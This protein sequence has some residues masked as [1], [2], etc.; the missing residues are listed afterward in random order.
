MGASFKQ[1]RSKISRPAIQ[2]QLANMENI[3]TYGRPLEAPK[4][5]TPM[6]APTPVPTPIAPQISARD[7]RAKGIYEGLSATNPYKAMLSQYFGGSQ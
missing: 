6:M 5:P 2:K 4:A 3:A 7:T 1:F